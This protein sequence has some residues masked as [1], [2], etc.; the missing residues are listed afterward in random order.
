MKRRPIFYL[1][2][3]A[4]ALSLTACNPEGERPVPAPAPTVQS[5]VP[6]PSPE[7]VATPAAEGEVPPGDYAPWQTAY[8]AFLTETVAAEAPLMDWAKTAT[9]TDIT[10]Q[11]EKWSAANDVSDSYSLYDVDKDGVP[12][13][14]IRHGLGE[15]GYHTVCYTIQEGAVV[16]L[17]DF[18]SGHSS[19]YS[20]P[21]ENA[22]IQQQGHMGQAAMG[23]YTI[24][25]NE[26]VFVEWFQEENI[27]ETGQEWYTDPAQLVEGAEYLPEYSIRR[28]REESGSPALTLPIYDYGALPRLAPSP[29]EE[30]EV[31]QVMERV[32]REN[33]EVNG[34]S[35]DS[36]YGGVGRVDLEEYLER[37]YPYSPLT[38][39]STAW[40]DANGDGQTDCV[41]RLKGR[42]GENTPSF[43]AVLQVQ[44]GTVYAYFF[45]FLEGVGVDPD[46]SVYFREWEDWRQVSFDR[47]QC[48]DFPALRDPVEGCNLAWDA[49]PSNP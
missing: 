29:L 5:P 45:G 26:L 16:E 27:N 19:L 9:E 36:F 20:W 33:G 24:E 23:K 39:I 22:L 15:A 37:A 32:L 8:A 12:E 47:E 10:T 13:L 25:N 18:G 38:I 34:C 43:Y 28:E 11:P 17:G 44:D 6:T 49:F 7:P 3:G 31:R 30:A 1:L 2:A 42:E 46:G 4:A 21:G 41:L 35:G 48:Y 40:A 14:F